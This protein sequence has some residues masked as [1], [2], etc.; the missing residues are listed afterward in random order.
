MQTDAVFRIM[1][2]TKPIVGV[3]ILMMMEEGKVRLTD[4][5]SQFVPE[6]QGLEGRRG[7]G[8][9]RRHDRS[10]PGEP[11]FSTVAADHEITVRE[12]L[13]HTSGFVSGTFSIA[14]RRE[15]SRSRG[16]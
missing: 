9:A 8:G 1:S 2:M 12:L 16:K 11:H 6:L 10:S 4:P 14:P 3:A 13:T 5:V 15:P 7:A